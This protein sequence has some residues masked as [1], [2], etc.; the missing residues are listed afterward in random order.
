MMM[1]KSEKGKR[2]RGHLFFKHEEK[3]DVVKKIA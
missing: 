3:E 2:R 1:M